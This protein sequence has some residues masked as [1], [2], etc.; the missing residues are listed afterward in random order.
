MERA[1]KVIA[2]RQQHH[3][4]LLR[5]GSDFSIACQVLETKA[6]L[7]Q[8]LEHQYVVQLLDVFISFH[9]VFLVMP[10]LLGGNL[11]DIIVERGKYI[12]HHHFCM[13]CH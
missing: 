11:L 10:Y 8:Q 5:H 7:L 3:S 2:I 12:H 4:S 6:S 9:G 13:E 1:V